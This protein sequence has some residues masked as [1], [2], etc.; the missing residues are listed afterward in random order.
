MKLVVNVLVELL[1]ILDQLAALIP[2]NNQNAPTLLMEIWSML[3]PMFTAGLLLPMTSLCAGA[4]SIPQ[5]SGT[6]QTHA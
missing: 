3:T 5:G 4:L 6:V 2:L 1:T